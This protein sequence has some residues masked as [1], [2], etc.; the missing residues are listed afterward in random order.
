MDVTFPISV[1]KSAKALLT[2]G[3]SVGLIIKSKGI[4]PDET[5]KTPLCV[6]MKESESPDDCA[7]R[8]DTRRS[9]RIESRQ[10]MRIW[11]ELCNQITKNIPINDPNKQESRQESPTE[12][13]ILPALS[14][15]AWSFPYKAIPTVRLRA[16]V[17]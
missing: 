8:T 3:H 6:E 9:K 17:R 1:C 2:P 15:L 16:F 14:F 10:G 13:S 12:G 4:L 5:E 7:R 11:S